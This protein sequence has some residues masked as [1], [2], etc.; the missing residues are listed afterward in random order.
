MTAATTA[1][2]DP[3]FCGQLH[4]VLIVSSQQR[5]HGRPESNRQKR[6]VAGRHSCCPRPLLVSP[7]QSLWIMQGT[8]LAITIVFFWVLVFSRG[9]PRPRRVVWAGAFPHLFVESTRAELDSWTVS[10]SEYVA[11]RGSTGSKLFSAATAIIGTLQIASAV[12]QSNLCIA[13]GVAFA[14]LVVGGCCAVVLG[15]MEAADPDPACERPGIRRSKMAYLYVHI[16]SA[17]GFLLFTTASE[18][19][20]S[21]RTIAGMICAAAGLAFFAA[22]CV[23]N[24]A[25]GAYVGDPKKCLLPQHARDRNAPETPIWMTSA[26]SWLNV[27]LVAMGRIALNIELAAFALTALSQILGSI[28]VTSA[29]SV[30]QLCAGLA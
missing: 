7:L 15:Q 11:C 5:A 2:D 8:A 21:T 27:H 10:V 6:Q 23:L 18:F 26:H 16:A 17:I 14:F 13:R 25:S 19:I 1:V 30:C 22:F 20:K 3:F 9:E 12:V 29:A 24:W 4:S 28:M